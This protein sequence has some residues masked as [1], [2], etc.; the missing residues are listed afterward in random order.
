M[1]EVRRVKLPVVAPGRTVRFGDLS[2]GGDTD[3]LVVQNGR[4]D[5]DI[6]LSLTALDSTGHVMWQR[7]GVLRDPPLLPQDVPVQIHD[8]DGDGKNEVVCYSAG[9]LQVLD[10]ATGAMKAEK[11]GPSMTHAQAAGGRFHC[12]SIHICNLAGGARATDLLVKDMYSNVFAY[13]A[14]L[15][16]RWHYACKTGHYPFTFDTNGDGKDEILIGYTLLTPAGERLWSIPL[17]DHA[18]A[19]AIIRS[20]KTDDLVVAIAAS[21]EGFVFADMQGKKRR[22]LKIGHMQTISAGRLLPGSDDIQI[23]TNTYWG[24][25]G[26]I[27]ILSLDG[28]VINVFQPSIHGSPLSLVRW[29]HGHQDFFLLS[30]A[31]GTRGRSL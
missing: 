24:N 26:V 7:G 30:A 25:P 5:E 2:G 11:P 21:N 12:D 17:T 27:Y 13:D 6:P 1:R 29:T 4:P 22:H 31:P 14:S 15:E 3:Y 28:K 18:D 8:I 20:R 23:A 10:G 9:T 16:A 19:V